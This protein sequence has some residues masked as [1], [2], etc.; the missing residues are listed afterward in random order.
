M[1]I[2]EEYERRAALEAVL[3][4]ELR[5]KLTPLGQRI[6]DAIC[7]HYE[8]EFD[9]YGEVWQNSLTWK[10][11]DLARQLKLSPQA[12]G[13]ALTRLEELRFV[14]TSGVDDVGRP[15]TFLGTY[16]STWRASDQWVQ[17]WAECLEGEVSQDWCDGHLAMFGIDPDGTGAGGGFAGL[18]DNTPDGMPDISDEL[19]KY[20]E[21]L[22]S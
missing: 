7:A 16:F 8:E 20:H 9:N 2:K 10:A 19:L 21:K 11:A 14:G 1:K 17:R 4:E 12:V 22:K 13:G 15:T 6:I 3:H 18:G 5:A